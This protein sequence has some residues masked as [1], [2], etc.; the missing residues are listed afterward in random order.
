MQGVGVPMG[1]E[2]KIEAIMAADFKT[3]RDLM[4]A[5]IKQAVQVGVPMSI[6][7]QATDKLLGYIEHELIILAAMVN[8]DQR[9]NIQGHQ[10]PVIAQELYNNFKAESMEDISVCFR[11]G[12]TGAYGEIYR[13]D[14]AVISGWMRHYLEEKYQVIES[15]MMAEKETFYSV[16]KSDKP[17]EQRNPERNLLAAM[18]TVLYGKDPGIDLSKHLK[19]EELK[20]VEEARKKSIGMKPE[21]NAE[22][23]AYQRYKLE[24]QAN[25]TFQDLLMKAA[26]NF[27][28]EKGGYKELKMFKDETTGTYCL[29]E[30]E[31]DAEQIYKIATEQ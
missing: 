6:I 30:S 1:L 29:A 19:P 16:K 26:T 21:N 24:R 20:E 5:T 13:L 15:N 31:S 28:Q 3:A 23:N 11:R 27:Y 7:S 22:D 9:L 8:V 10:L 12:S 17:E 25:P 14:A 4:P 2:N 18:E